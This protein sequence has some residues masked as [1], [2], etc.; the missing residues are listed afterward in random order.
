MAAKTKNLIDDWNSQSTDQLPAIDA[1]LGDIYSG[2]QT[3][4]LNAADR[5]YAN[6]HLF[7]LSGLYG[8]LRACDSVHPYR[9]EMGYKFPDEPYTSLYSFWNR[10]IADILPPSNIVINLSAVE[11]TKA[12]LPYLKEARIITPKFMTFDQKSQM[13]KFVTV[14]AKIARGAFARWLIQNRIEAVDALSTFN[15]LG[16]Q[17][18]AE[19]STPDSPVFVCHEFK[20]LGLS[21]RLR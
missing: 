8:V 2:F 18:D 6:D 17:F 13:P 7:I 11:Y 16:Y 3:H 20:G 19:L 12:V 15:D 4:T 1:F 10:R 5:T 9:L 21:V 14:H